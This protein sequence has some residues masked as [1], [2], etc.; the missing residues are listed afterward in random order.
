[1]S[2]YYVKKLY[3]FKKSIQMIADKH[4]STKRKENILAV[5]QAIIPW[6]LKYVLKRV[7]A[8]AFHVERGTSHIPLDSDKEE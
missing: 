1:M 6:V 8:C 5:K 7:K 2:T 4:V 3:P